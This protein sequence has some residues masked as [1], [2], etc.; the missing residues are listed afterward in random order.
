MKKTINNSVRTA[1]F[2]IILFVFVGIG[3]SIKHLDGSYSYVEEPSEITPAVTEEAGRIEPVIY[4]KEELAVNR[5]V[6]SRPFPRARLV[7]F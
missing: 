1:V 5:K 2:I 7:Q 3:P 6:A 4:R